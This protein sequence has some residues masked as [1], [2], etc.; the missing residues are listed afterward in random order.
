MVRCKNACQAINAHA[1]SNI[2]FLGMLGGCTV[3][4]FGLW[5]GSARHPFR[6]QLLGLLR[7]LTRN[8]SPTSEVGNGCMDR[9]GLPLRPAT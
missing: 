7:W 2:D 4:P 8:D 9:I 5:L 6:W 1:A 3:F